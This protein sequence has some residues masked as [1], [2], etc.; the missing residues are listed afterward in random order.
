M[1]DDDILE[2]AGAVGLDALDTVTLRRFGDGT[3]SAEG[4]I[5]QIAN[6]LKRNH[7]LLAEVMRLRRAGRRGSAR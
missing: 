1:T 6:L 5:I 4:A 7:I 3:M 2:V